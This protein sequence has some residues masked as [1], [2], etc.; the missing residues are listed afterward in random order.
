MKRTRW[1][2]NWQLPLFW[3]GVILSQKIIGNLYTVVNEFVEGNC[4]TAHVKG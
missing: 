1:N 2:S 4:A 3:K